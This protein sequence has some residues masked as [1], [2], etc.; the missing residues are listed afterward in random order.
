M[1]FCYVLLHF[2]LHIAVFLLHFVVFCFVFAV[3]LL[4][5]G[6]K[7]FLMGSFCCEEEERRLLG[8]IICRSLITY[9]T[10]KM[11]P[12]RP[13]DDLGDPCDGVRPGSSRAHPLARAPSPGAPGASKLPGPI[14]DER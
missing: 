1:P 10:R 9:R 11:R 7:M 3:F 13:R 5:Y 12:A 14:C 6:F 8:N 4:Y 2:L